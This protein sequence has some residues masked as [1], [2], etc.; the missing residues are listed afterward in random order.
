M[1]PTLHENTIVIHIRGGDIF[2]S[3]PHSAYMPHK[4]N[5]KKNY[6]DFRDRSNPCVNKLL[7]LYPI[8]EF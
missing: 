6:Y 4:Y 1:S 2:S 7:V 5:Y 3:Y 8:I